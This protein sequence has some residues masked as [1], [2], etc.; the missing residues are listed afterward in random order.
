M[1]YRVKSRR[2]HRLTQA[3]LCVLL[4]IHVLPAADPLPVVPM[5]T[6]PA[7]LAHSLLQPN[8]EFDA[9]VLEAFP[10]SDDA[11]VT[12][13][14]VQLDDDPELEAIL[15]MKASFDP[16]GGYAGYVFDP[17]GATWNRVG[18]F[19]FFRQR[20]G[21]GLLPVRK[22]TEDSPT[23]IL[24][25]RDL[26]GSASTIMTTT[27]YQLRDGKLWPVIEVTNFQWN[28]LPPPETTEHRTVLASKDRLVIHTLTEQSGRVRNT[29]EVQF[30][31]SKNHQF[32]PA[33]LDFNLYCDVHTGNPI[34]GKA[35]P[36]GLPVF[37]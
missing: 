2:S 23:L 31:D 35:H 33:P 29:C 30:W 17:Q 26:G 19:L 15:T 14:W 16:S 10:P 25:T 36:T 4:T 27:A 22:L 3:A 21:N 5:K 6:D 18:S 8:S 34:P 12:L 11:D 13:R 32:A 1:A 7:R 20:E 28:G 24:F 37:P 9:S